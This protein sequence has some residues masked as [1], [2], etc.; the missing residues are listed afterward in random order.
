MVGTSSCSPRWRGYS[1]PGS[2]GAQHFKNADSRPDAIGKRG[3]AV[4]RRPDHLRFDDQPDRQ[5]SQVQPA[6]VRRQ[7]GWRPPKS[8]LLRCG[9]FTIV[10]QT[11][12][13]CDRDPS[14]CSLPRKPSRVG[15]RSAGAAG[16]IC[17]LSHRSPR[18]WQPQPV[19]GIGSLRLPRRS[20]SG[21]SGRSCRHRSVFGSEA[22][23]T[24]IGR[25]GSPRSTGFLPQGGSVRHFVS[26]FLFR[27]TLFVRQNVTDVRLVRRTRR[28][29]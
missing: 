7:L 24:P 19:T 23:W 28:T 16:M 2:W 1:R 29:P 4:R 18:N 5:C 25:T 26:D 22:E 13:W 12:R 6:R 15:T 10:A 27:P 17:S 21:E 14:K 20:A 8:R 11:T 9:S 3:F